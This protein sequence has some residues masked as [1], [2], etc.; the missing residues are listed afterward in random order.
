MLRSGW[1][2]PTRFVHPTLYLWGGNGVR[3]GE[4]GVSRSWQGG[5]RFFGGYLLAQAMEQK[6]LERLNL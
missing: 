5:L 6:R 3:D 1:N 4:G 2:K